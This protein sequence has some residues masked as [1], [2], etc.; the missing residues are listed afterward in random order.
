MTKWKK[1]DQ[2]Y[3]QHPPTLRT[4][5]A[6]SCWC[7]Q[8]W[9]CLC[10]K[11]LIFFPAMTWKKNFKVSASFPANFFWTNGRGQF[12]FLL[13]PGYNINKIRLFGTRCRFWCRL[14]I[15]FLLQCDLFHKCIYT[16]KAVRHSGQLIVTALCPSLNSQN[17]PFLRF[18]Y[19]LWTLF[20]N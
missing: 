9:A 5:P 8:A 14:E 2:A 17:I 11:S 20:L 1:N 4:A 10:Q 15:E 7:P 12:V 3:L 6:S 19:M 18:F 16:E 13:L